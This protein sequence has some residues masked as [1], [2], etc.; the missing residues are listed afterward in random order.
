MTSS[1]YTTATAAPGTPVRVIA[2]S[3]RPS[4][5]A[6]AASTWVPVIAPA[7]DAVGGAWRALTRAPDR[8]VIAA[9]DRVACMVRRRVYRRLIRVQF[10]VC[11][12]SWVHLMPER[13]E[14]GAEG[15]RVLP[16]DRSLNR[17]LAIN[18]AGDSGV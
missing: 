2:S 18:E 1:L 9:A 3:I 6:T 7:S 14:L 16:A 5:W 11:T 12:E 17:N 10:L 8:A 4:S 13:R 15:R